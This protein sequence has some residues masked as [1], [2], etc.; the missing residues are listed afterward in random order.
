MARVGSLTADQERFM[1]WRTIDGGEI[2]AKGSPEMKVLIEIA[3]QINP[4]RMSDIM[5]QMSAE[6]AERLTVEMAARANGGGGGS[7]S[8]LPKIEGKPNGS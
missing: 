6:S 2:A 3:S 8:E 1:P 4:R 5:A 7:A